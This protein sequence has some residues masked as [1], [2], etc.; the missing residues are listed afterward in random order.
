M[1]WG[2][3]AARIPGARVDLSMSWMQALILSKLLLPGKLGSIPEMR[4][5]FAFWRS[6]LKLIW[7][8]VSL[9]SLYLRSKQGQ[10]RENFQ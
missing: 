7:N 1:S 8:H 3:M 9:S 6:S 4:V 5:I 2:S 10:W